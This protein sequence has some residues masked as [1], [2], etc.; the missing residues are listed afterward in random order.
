MK[1]EKRNLKLIFTDSGLGGINIMA[2]TADFFLKEKPS[3]K[4]DLIY[5]NST[6]DKQIGY[7]KLNSEEEKIFVFNR[8]LYSMKKNFNPDYIFIV[9]NTLSVIY[10][11]TEFSEREKIQVEGIVEYSLQA[12]KEKLTG[13]PESIVVIL[14]TPTTINKNTYKLNLIENEIDE[15]RIINQACPEL[16]S[17]IQKD[18]E[19]FETKILIKKYLSEAVR[20]IADKNTK[21]FLALCC[22]HYGFAEKVFDKVMKELGFNN[23]E[24]VDPNKKMIEGIKKKFGGERNQQIQVNCRVVSKVIFYEEEINS[25]SK[26]IEKT[27]PIVSESLRN[28]E[29]R[30]DLF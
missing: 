10:K 24:I 9:C 30:V 6:P 12:M 3:G 16:E 7:N 2:N 17:E 18:P 23:F 8:A 22:T 1:N 29:L 5:F 11:Q 25:I 4:I 19:S 13:E 15:R 26:L 28:Y 20:M 14:G 21:V 27:S